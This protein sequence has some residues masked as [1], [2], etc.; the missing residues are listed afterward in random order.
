MFEVDAFRWPSGVGSSETFASALRG[1]C[2]KIT[3]SD[4]WEM[5][6][7]ATGLDRRIPDSAFEVDPLL[8]SARVEFSLSGHRYSVRWKHP[9]GASLESMPGLYQED[10]IVFPCGVEVPGAGA[11]LDVAASAAGSG[12][13]RHFMMKQNLFSYLDEGASFVTC[14][15]SAS[16]GHPIS[17]SFHVRGTDNAE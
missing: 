9:M 10:V 1:T 13:G 15:G 2:K 12:F 16:D 8:R 17:M 7:H 14:L 3:H 6:C 4:G 5:G 11:G